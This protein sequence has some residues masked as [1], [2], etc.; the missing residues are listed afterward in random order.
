MKPNSALRKARVRLT[1]NVEV[2]AIFQGLATIWQ[3]HS[4]VLIKAAES[5]I[6]Q[7]SEYHIIRGALDAEG[8]PNR[9]KAR[10]RMELRNPKRKKVAE[11]NQSEEDMKRPRDAE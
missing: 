3:E 6:C 10:S 11:S 5:K 4:I 9:F 7:A 2:T 1:N 8:R